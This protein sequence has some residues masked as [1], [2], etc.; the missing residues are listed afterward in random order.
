MRLR[1]RPYRLFAVDS[2][3]ALGSCAAL[4]GIFGRLVTTGIPTSVYGSLAMIALL[5]AINSAIQYRTGAPRWQLRL[6][7]VAIANLLYCVLT[8]GLVVYFRDR[9]TTLEWIYLPAEIAVVAALAALELITSRRR[10]ARPADSP[11]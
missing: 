11:A 7:F 10:S 5:F 9:L 4:Y 2:L 6:A 1:D 3:G 8:A